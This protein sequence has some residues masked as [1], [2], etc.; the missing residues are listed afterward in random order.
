[1]E[2]LGDAW[3]R[4]CTETSELVTSFVASLR[5]ADLGDSGSEQRVR[6]AEKLRWREL[7]ALLVSHLATEIMERAWES[8]RPLLDELERISLFEHRQALLAGDLPAFDRFCDQ[9]MPTEVIAGAY[10]ALVRAIDEGS[11]VPVD[12]FLEDMSLPPVDDELRGLLDG[13]VDAAMG[14]LDQALSVRP[15]LIPNPGVLTVDITTGE[16]VVEVPVGAE[17]PRDIGEPPW[18]HSG[19]ADG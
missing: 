13:D 8:A 14:R 18:K 16:P 12:T 5:T 10:S 6:V 11:A 9:S 4:K 2:G 15:R 19:A 17:P 1:M 7:R 3:D